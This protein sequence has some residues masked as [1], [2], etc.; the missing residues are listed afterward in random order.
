MGEFMLPSCGLRQSP[1]LFS[2][3]RVEVLLCWKPANT[4][5]WEQPRNTDVSC[6]QALPSPPLPKMSV[7]LS[8][9]SMV[10]PHVLCLCLP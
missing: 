3:Q 5:Q 10:S 6:L 7:H 2:N 4:S 9:S 8:A 1:D